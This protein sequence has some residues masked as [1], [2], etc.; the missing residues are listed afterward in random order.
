MAD[1]DDITNRLKNRLIS[2]SPPSQ[3]RNYHVPVSSAYDP[4]TSTLKSNQ[5]VSPISSLHFT[6]QD[7]DLLMT[8]SNEAESSQQT[9]VD[10]GAF[11]VTQSSEKYQ[12]A[13]DSHRSDRSDKMDTLK[14]GTNPQELVNQVISEGNIQYS[15]RD[16]LTS[17]RSSPS[18]RDNNSDTGIHMTFVTPRD[19]ETS[20]STGGFNTTGRDNVFTPREL[21]SA[22]NTPRDLSVVYEVNESR[23]SSDCTSLSLHQS[24]SA[25]GSFNTSPKPVCQSKNNNATNDDSPQKDMSVIQEYVEQDDESGNEDENYYHRYRDVLDQQDHQEEGDTSDSEDEG[26]V[27]MPRTLNDV[28]GKFGGMPGHSIVGGSASLGTPREFTHSEHTMPF[29]VRTLNSE[30]T[31]TTFNKNSDSSDSDENPNSYFTEKQK[32]IIPVHER[33]SFIE[34][35]SWFSDDERENVRYVQQND[36]H[37]V[38]PVLSDAEQVLSSDDEQDKTPINKHNLTKVQKFC[39]NLLE[40]LGINSIESVQ[41]YED[42]FESYQ[43]SKKSSRVSSRSGHH[44]EQITPNE[45]EYSAHTKSGDS[46]RMNSARSDRSNASTIQEVIDVD[47]QSSSGSRVSSARSDRSNRSS[48]VDIPQETNKF[49]TTMVSK[50]PQEIYTEVVSELDNIFGHH[51]N[52]SHAKC[53]QDSSTSQHRPASSGTPR[54]GLLGGHGNQLTNGYAEEG[55]HKTSGLPEAESVPNFFMPAQHLEESMKALRL[56]TAMP[57]IEQVITN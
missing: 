15:A 19:D 31:R 11:S 39:D 5:S 2:T 8:G 7:N 40:D 22:D 29:D 50:S 49:T 53:S 28:S 42:D 38:L 56:A 47:E 9:A 43:T 32:S 4:L 36:K 23:A 6:K 14:L 3:Q 34:K 37:S 51:G 17:D 13:L 52:D 35:D 46:S 24:D 41:S 27:I 33:S 45:D 20:M 18:P 25:P 26:E 44:F 55:S 12:D 48:A 57:H 1:L 16:A 54:D 30:R 10:S 21:A